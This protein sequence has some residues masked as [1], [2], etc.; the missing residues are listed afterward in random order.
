MEEAL[1]KELAERILAEAPEKRLPCKKAF[2]IA[3]EFDCLPVDVGRLCDELGVK[4]CG[5][6][7]GCF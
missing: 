4:I 5:C 7:L 1:K 6:Q 2:A 3:A